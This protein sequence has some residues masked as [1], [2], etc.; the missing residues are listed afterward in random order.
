MGA[1]AIEGQ[2]LLELGNALVLLGETAQA[3]ASLRQSI[4]ILTRCGASGHL[5]QAQRSLDS[6]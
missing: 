6:L 3:S 2:A 1:R 4:A 5:E